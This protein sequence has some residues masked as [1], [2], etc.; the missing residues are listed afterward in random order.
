MLRKSVKTVVNKALSEKAYNNTEF[1][2]IVYN[3]DGI[4]QSKLIEK[5]VD[6][7]SVA[8]LKDILVVKSIEIHK[9]SAKA[10]GKYK[11]YKCKDE[12][13]DLYDSMLEL[14]VCK[15]FYEYQKAGFISEIERQKP[16]SFQKIDPDLKRL[17]YADIIFK[18]NKT[19]SIK[20]TAKKPLTFTADQKYVCDVKS[21]LTRKDSTFALKK[22]LMKVAFGI[23]VVLIVRSYDKA[24]KTNRIT[25]CKITPKKVTTVLKST[26]RKKPVK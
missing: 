4:Y 24:K 16:F 18:C 19:F 8:N 12:L 1:N 5:Q 26:K 11:S 21:P 23:T 9:Q 13:G 7:T 15:E 6:P 22:V 2:L 10:Q 25:K 17:Y 14:I 3:V 20:T